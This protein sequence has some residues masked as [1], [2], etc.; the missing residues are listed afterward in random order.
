MLPDGCVVV[1]VASDVV[2]VGL[3]DGIVVVVARGA[4]VVVAFVAEC[5]GGL[6]FN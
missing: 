4:V 6:Y 1:D 2:V 5:E 3:V